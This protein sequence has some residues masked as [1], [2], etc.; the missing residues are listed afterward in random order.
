[1]S[2][3]SFTI[4]Q[5]DK[6]ESLQYLPEYCRELSLNGLSN[7]ITW[8]QNNIR[9]FGK[10]IPEPRLT[11]W[12]GAAYTYSGIYW[13]ENSIP[14]FLSPIFVRLRNDFDFDFNSV[15]I[16][17]YRDGKDSMGW[18]RDNEPEMDQELIA[19]ISL[20][21]ARIFKVKNRASGI[22]Q[23]ILLENQSL[24]LMRNFQTN[25]MHSIP[26]SNKVAEPRINLTFRRIK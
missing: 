1:M 8:R 10:T 13:P 3:Q 24:L 23:N 20:G 14:D 21:S 25:W 19:S 7:Q 4:L 17:F 11:A 16:N 2:Q 26:K 22:S 6:G 18:H 9:I 15:L 12:F 5:N